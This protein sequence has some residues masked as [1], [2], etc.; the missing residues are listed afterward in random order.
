MLSND[1]IDEFGALVN[2]VV[3]RTR[4]MAT[5]EKIAGLPVPALPGNISFSC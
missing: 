2:S 3:E 5:G 1:L 4:D